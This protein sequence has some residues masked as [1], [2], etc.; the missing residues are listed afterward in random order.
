MIV[1]LSRLICLTILLSTLF[2]FDAA[3]ASDENQNLIEFARMDPMVVRMGGETFKY[4]VKV[5]DSSITQIELLEDSPLCVFAYSSFG[6]NFDTTSIILKDD[7]LNGDSLAGDGILTFTG[8]S[9]P[10][11]STSYNAIWNTQSVAETWNSSREQQVR[12]SYSNGTQLETSLHIDVPCGAISG[13]VPIP[14]ITELNGDDRATANV[15]SLTLPET[16][17][18]YPYYR[19]SGRR[20]SHEVIIEKVVSYLKGEYDWLVIQDFGGESNVFYSR[21]RPWVG[22]SE[23]PFQPS[24]GAP[25]WLLGIMHD[26]NGWA[27]ALGNAQGSQPFGGDYNTTNHELLHSWASFL[28]SELSISDGSGHYGVVIEETSC[29]NGNG[30]HTYSSYDYNQETGEMRVPLAGRELFCNTLELYLM[31]LLPSA[32]VKPITVGVNPGQSTLEGSNFV[33]PVEGVREVKVDDIIALIGEREPLPVEPKPEFKA[34]MVLVHDRKLTD[35]ELALFDYR[36]KDMARARSQHG[37]TF[38]E[39]VFD[40]ATL[41][42]KIDLNVA[43]PEID[44]EWPSVF[45]GQAPRPALNLSL[46]NIGYFNAADQTL[47]TCLK[48]LNNAVASSLNGVEKFDV[49]FGV[50]TSADSDIRLVRTRPFNLQAA[51]TDSGETPS[52][53]GSFDVALGRYEDVIQL[54]EQTLSLVLGLVEGSNLELKLLSA[55]EL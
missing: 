50:S 8:L 9:V 22:V 26:Q 6:I 47:Y 12:I 7:G 34:V 37:K 53:S 20:Y 24:G 3:W 10:D 46:N 13:N 41:S 1:S 51:L 23:F 31:G 33:F 42:T 19:D 55:T 45:N 44:L 25:Q 35:T 29:M 30:I 38:Q 11:V 28:P 18:P 16:A 52:C 49:A 36:M 5:T 21:S 54:G 14:Q 17:L 4:Q 40:R 43:T 48:I 32:E 15:L 27:S 39:V 2:E